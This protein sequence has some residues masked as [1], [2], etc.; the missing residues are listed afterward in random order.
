MAFHSVLAFL[1]TTSCHD[2]DL[3]S[4]DPVS[5]LWTNPHTPGTENQNLAWTAQS[6]AVRLLG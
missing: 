4:Q 6:L 3:D 2:C 1:E 5:A